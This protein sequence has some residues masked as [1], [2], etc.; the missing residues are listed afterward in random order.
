LCKESKQATDCN[1]TFSENGAPLKHG[2][3]LKQSKQKSTRMPFDGG[4][5]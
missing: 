2:F 5:L 3:D 4:E 1:A